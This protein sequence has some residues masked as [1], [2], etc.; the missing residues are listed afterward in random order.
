MTRHATRTVRLFA[1]YN[2]AVE[3]QHFG[4]VRS[5]SW[6]EVVGYIN[7]THRHA[8]ARQLFIEGTDGKLRPLMA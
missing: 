5:G 3:G 4:I 7:A 8:G 2:N 1:L 6:S